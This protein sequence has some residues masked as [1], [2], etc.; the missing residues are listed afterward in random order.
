MLQRTWVKYGF[1]ALALLV[2]AACFDHEADPLGPRSQTA[3]DQVGRAVVTN[4][5]PAVRRVAIEL[6]AAGPFQSGRPIAI[7]ARVASDLAADQVRLVLLVLDG[8]SVEEAKR[9]PQRLG[10]W[11]GA[12]ARGSRQELAGSVT[13]ARAGYYRVAAISSSQPSEN[14]PVQ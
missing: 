10:E 13:F 8:E 5:F 6:N 14:S 7:S 12:L 3:Q 4:E 2:G 11:S 9:A 1:V